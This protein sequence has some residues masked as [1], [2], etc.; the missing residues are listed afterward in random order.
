MIVSRR[1]LVGMGTVFVA[2]PA[3]VRAANLMAVSAAVSV[4]R[5]EINM[6]PPWIPFGEIPNGGM[7]VEEVV[8][9]AIAQFAALGLGRA[10]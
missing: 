9:D 5:F 10:R 3:I 7:S 6:L 8:K 2:A 4:P 1:R